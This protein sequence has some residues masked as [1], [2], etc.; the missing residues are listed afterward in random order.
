MKANCVVC[1]AEFQRISR[2][3]TCGPDCN[4]A[5]RQAYEKSRKRDPLPRRKVNC[6]VCGKEFEKTKAAKTCGAIC[7]KVRQKSTNQ[8]AQK[9]RNLTRNPKTSNC[10]VCGSKFV[11]RNNKKTCSKECME[12]NR[13]SYQVAYGQT[14]RQ[15]PQYKEYVRAY[16]KIYREE[17][18]YKLRQREY[19]HSAKG[20]LAKQLYQQGDLRKRYDNARR[21]LPHRVSYHKQ[22]STNWYLSKSAAKRLGIPSILYASLKIIDRFTK[23]QE[24]AS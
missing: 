12:L 16:G 14:Q 15:T 23:S 1:G 3:K 18:A 5:Y 7:S 21:H 13:A 11:K 10:I 6:V 22:Y 24:N 20:K 8:S 9:K 17:P 19:Y 4:K 2:A